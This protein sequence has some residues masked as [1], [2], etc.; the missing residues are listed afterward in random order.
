MMI[1]FYLFVVCLAMQGIL[2]YIYPV[3]HTAE[4][5]VLYWKSPLE[6]L[7]DKGWNGWGNYMMLSGVLLAVMTTLYFIFR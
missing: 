2:S 5:A 7:R 6:P 1:A 3:R 4:S